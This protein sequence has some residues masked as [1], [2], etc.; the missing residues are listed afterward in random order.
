MQKTDFK[1]GDGG[2]DPV[3]ALT[4]MLTVKPQ[5]KMR[6]LLKKTKAWMTGQLH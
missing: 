6:I 1:G 5:S 2:I 4:D 3:I